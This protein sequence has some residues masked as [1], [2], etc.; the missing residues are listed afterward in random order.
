MFHGFTDKFFKESVTQDVVSYFLFFIITVPDALR[1]LKTLLQVIFGKRQTPTLGHLLTVLIREIGHVIGLF[2]LLYKVAPS[3]NPLEFTVVTVTIP[4]V[5]GFVHVVAYCGRRR[6]TEYGWNT[7]KIVKQLLNLVAMFLLL[8][9][10]IGVPVII[11]QNSTVISSKAEFIGWEIASVVLLSTRWIET[12]SSRNIGK[13]GCSIPITSRALEEGHAVVHLCSSFFR[14]IVAIIVFPTIFC[15]GIR[16]INDTFEQFSRQTENVTGFLHETICP[17]TTISNASIACT[18]RLEVTLWNVLGPFLVHFLSAMLANHCA[19]VACKLCMQTFSFSIPLSLAS[20]VY[21][22]ILIVLSETNTE[23]LYDGIGFNTISNEYGILLGFFIAGWLAQLW[24]CN[25]VWGSAGEERLA[26][27]RKLFVLPHFVSAYIDLSMLHSRKRKLSAQTSKREDKDTPT[28]KVYI[29]ATMWHENRTEMKQILTSIFRLDLDQFA[30]KANRKLGETDYYEFEAHIPF[31]DAMETSKSHSNQRTINDFVRQLMEIVEVAGRSFY[32]KDVNLIA[33][34]YVTPY[35][36]RLEWTL[37]GQNKLIAHLKDKDKIRHKKRWSQIMYMYYFA[38]YEL[39]MKHKNEFQGKI[40]NFRDL[41]S[42]FDSNGLTKKIMDTAN[43]TY[44][45]ALDGDVDFYPEAL[46][47]LIDRMKKN[48]IVGATCG[49]IKPGGSGPLVWY[50]R[51]EYAIGHWLQKSA[52]HVFGCVLCSPGCFSMFRMKALMD[53]NVMRTYASLPTE[54]KHFLQYDQGEDRW[55]CTLLLQ[56]GYRIEYCAAAEALTFAPEEFKEFF[57]QRRRWMPSTMANIWDLLASHSRTTKKNTNISY[58]YI[59]YQMVLFFSSILGPSTVL[60][61]M[62]SAINS[63]FSI[64]T[65][66]GYCLVYVPVILFIVAC[67]KLKS[68][69]QLNIAMVLSAVYALLMM[70][71]F[72][73][74]LVSIASEGWYTP[75]GMDL[76]SRIEP[77]GFVFLVVFTVLLLMQLVGMLI[78]RYGTL[79]HIISATKLGK[80]SDSEESREHLIE[81]LK[82]SDIQVDDEDNPI[83]GDLTDLS[84]DKDVLHENHRFRK[85]VRNR[86]SSQEDPVPPVP[87]RIPRNKQTLD[88]RKTLRANYGK[89]RQSQGRAGGRFNKAY[90]TDDV[91]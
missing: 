81:M 68:N 33:Q 77:L 2:G 63:V 78:H 42:L 1:F 16:D 79:L 31:D 58:F 67:L 70:A 12:Y 84:I 22:V 7:R 30:R 51:F 64:P 10:L 36:G 39:M 57:N 3:L 50:Q 21:V 54:P 5:I 86:R 71:V 60:L 47:L 90:R 75:T 61:A 4:A 37:P 19:V 13:K 40:P 8:G 23:V 11:T 20:P 35:G 69:T 9:L 66:L 87:R 43:Y 27:T 29:C 26:F 56:Q 6:K 53:D 48:P 38:G 91:V 24:I 18:D 44:I 45:L 76:L 41:N 82:D 15:N 25:H 28:P 49:R 34:K 72:V 85:T 32:K 46:Q 14:L 55:L 74:T 88:L 73:G 17:N 83:Y 62:N 89:A 59:I 80:R 52:E 65:W